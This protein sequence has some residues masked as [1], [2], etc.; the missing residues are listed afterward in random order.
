MKR[1]AF[2]KILEQNG[3]LF[4]KHGSEHDIYQNK[5]TGKKVTVPRHGEID[6]IFAKKILSQS[7]E[8]NTK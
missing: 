7:K 1:E 2:I 5:E 6:N 3:V 4:F 8:F